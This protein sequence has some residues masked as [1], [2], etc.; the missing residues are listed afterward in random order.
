[1]TIYD[2]NNNCVICDKY[3]YDQHKKSCKHYVQESY[4]EFLTR[5]KA[6]AEG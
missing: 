6:E 1:M 4:S 3:V 2:E 5:I